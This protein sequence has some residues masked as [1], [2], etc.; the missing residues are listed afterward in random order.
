MYGDVFY[1]HPS[2]Q[3]HK[4]L[5]DAAVEEVRRRY[6]PADSPAKQ[7]AMDAELA[8]L[9]ASWPDKHLR[10]RSWPLWKQEQ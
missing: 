5:R 3:M 6:E 2:R 10:E 9:R 8:E 1:L 4:R 7:A